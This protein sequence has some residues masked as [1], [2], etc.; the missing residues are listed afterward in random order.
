MDKNESKHSKG[1]LAAKKSASVVLTITATIFIV[2]WTVGTIVMIGEKIVGG[3]IMFAV[4]WAASVLLLLK[5]VQMDKLVALYKRYINTI[6]NQGE[7]G[8]EKIAAAVG[9]DRNKVKKELQKMINKGYFKNTAI[10]EQKNQIVLFH[11][12]VQMPDVATGAAEIKAC[13]SCGAINAIHADT[14]SK[15]E[16]CGCYLKAEASH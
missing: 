4:L 16:F 2:F 5:A 12:P 15:C 6:V 10:N 1:R 3:A 13:A 11:L 8:I 7:R 14:V 9:R